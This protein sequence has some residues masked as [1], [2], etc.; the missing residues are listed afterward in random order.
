[1]WLDPDN[2]RELIIRRVIAEGGRSRVSINGRLATL[3]VLAQLGATLVQIYGQ[4][5]QQ[6]LLQRENHLLILDR[7]AGLETELAAYRELYQHARERQAKLAILEQRERERSDLLELAR[8][9]VEELEHAQMRAGEDGELSSERIVLTNAARLAEAANAAEQTLYGAE[10]AAIDLISRMRARLAE[11]A[12][13]DPALNS[14]LEMIVAAQVNLE[15]AARTLSA[16][17]ERIE[18]D[19]ARLEQIEARLQELS[20]LKRKYGGTIESAL[21]TLASSRT[22]I[23]ELEAAAETR[24]AA[25]AEMGQAL[26]QLFDAARRLSSRRERSAGELKHRMEAELKT[27]GMRN[28]EFEPRIGHLATADAEFTHGGLAAGPS[29][30]DT[31]E[32]DLAPNLGQA[33][34]PLQ[35]VAS[36]GELSRVMLALK[37][38]EAQRRGVATLIFDEVDAGI[39]GAAAEIV[40]RKLKQLARFH[41]ILCVTHLAQI[42]AFADSHFVV[43]K[44]ERGGSTRSHVSELKSSDRAVEVARM[45]GGNEGSDKF[46]RAARELVN[47]ARQ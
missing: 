19:P 7:H 24:A 1:E 45:L 9:R 6:S 17:A 27:L 12:A 42:A 11:A 44:E 46:L 4:H 36:G 14:A 34:I 13:I 33:P 22:E 29:G 32:F 18:A 30:I 8:F 25:E 43:Q 28:A 10:G 41:Q 16:Y 35:R 3:Q 26:E 47:R 23:T 21:E 31:V 5:E 2:P 39:G 38:L 15:E 37:W 20:R 40:G